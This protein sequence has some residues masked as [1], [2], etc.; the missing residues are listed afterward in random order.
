[1]GNGFFP[2]REK[3]GV[4]ERNLK[5]GKE[6]R[7]RE[8]Q[9]ETSELRRPP[10]KLQR[11]GHRRKRERELERERIGIEELELEIGKEEGLRF[12]TDLVGREVEPKNHV[13]NFSP[14]P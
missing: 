5:E 4:G 13:K 2:R 1:M 12:D 14:L 9:R 11:R 10:E 3:L 7:K 6:P 8:K